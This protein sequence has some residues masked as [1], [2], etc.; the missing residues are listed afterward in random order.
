[1]NFLSFKLRMTAITKMNKQ[2]LGNKRNL[3]CWLVHIPYSAL[4]KCIFLSARKPT[5]KAQIISLTQC[6]ISSKVAE[7]D[8]TSS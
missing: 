8:S 2:I 5:F 6:T 3:R 1:M 4:R 7:N